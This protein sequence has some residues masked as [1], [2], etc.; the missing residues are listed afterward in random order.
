M[1]ISNLHA[2]I[3]AASV[4]IAGVTPGTVLIAFTLYQTVSSDR[5]DP[6]TFLQKVTTLAWHFFQQHWQ[7]YKGLKTTRM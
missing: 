3:C 4:A 2:F 5:L 1:C 6:K 7:W